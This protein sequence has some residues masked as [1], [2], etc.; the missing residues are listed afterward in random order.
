MIRNV[1][2]RVYCEFFSRDLRYFL[3]RQEKAAIAAAFDVGSP[4]GRS[5]IE[6]PVAKI[7]PSAIQWLRTGQSGPS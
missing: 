1:P 3:S 7:D 4:A 6:A 2:C 5:F